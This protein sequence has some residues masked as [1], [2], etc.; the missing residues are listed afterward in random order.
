MSEPTKRVE[1]DVT[2]AR[3]DLMG[4]PVIRWMFRN[5]VVYR[6]A[7]DNIKLDKRRSMEK[8]D[9]VVAMANAY[10]GYMSIDEDEEF[11]F[12][13]VPFVRM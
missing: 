4:N 7:N 6:D 2:A 1:A 5:V 13:G 12:H 11:R 3:V 9:G 8:I 10:G